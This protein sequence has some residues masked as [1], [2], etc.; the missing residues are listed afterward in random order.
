MARR[1][2]TATD[3]PQSLTE[4]LPL[5]SEYARLE[6][7]ISQASAEREAGIAAL[8]AE[9]DERAA[10]MLSALSDITV[11]IKTWFEANRAGL[12]GGKRKSIEIGGCEIGHRTGNPALKPPKGMN[13]ALTITWL[14]LQNEPWA[15]HLIRVAET[16][17]KAAMIRVL[18]LSE[19]SLATTRLK[20]AGY[21][22]KQGESFFIK[23]AA[24]A[25]EAVIDIPVSGSVQ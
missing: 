8:N 11:R 18:R 2:S 25:P 23:S 17:D 15:Q 1:K 7:I 13:D 4:A 16:L 24:P 10:P 20:E 6:A 12:T 5:L 19:P 21:E 14:K 9:Y 22:T 3:A